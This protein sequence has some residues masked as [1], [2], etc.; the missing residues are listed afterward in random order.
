MDWAITQSFERVLSG[1]SLNK[2]MDAEELFLLKRRIQ[3]DLSDAQII[4]VLRRAFEWSQAEASVFSF[5]LHYRGLL[6]SG[7]V[8]LSEKT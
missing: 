4:E 3:R 1:M 5:V 8:R 7:N 6:K 2:M